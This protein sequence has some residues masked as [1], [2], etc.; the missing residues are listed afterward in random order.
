MKNAC[1]TEDCGAV[2]SQQ[3]T[4]HPDSFVSLCGSQLPG[5]TRHSGS[6]QRIG[7]RVIDELFALAIPG[8]RPVQ[9]NGGLGN[10]TEGVRPNRFIDRTNS[11]TANFDGVQ[12]IANVVRT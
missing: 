11:W 6:Q 4:F 10:M 3:R 5:W 7:G 9:S 8:Y 2:A 1:L 12:E